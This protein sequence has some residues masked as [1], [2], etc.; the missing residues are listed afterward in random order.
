[1]GVSEVNLGFACLSYKFAMISK[2]GQK[3]SD[4]GGAACY[5]KKKDILESKLL[6]K[7]S[8]LAVILYLA[9]QSN[10]TVVFP[11]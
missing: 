11:F 1:M 9:N 6:E 4:A 10:F 3:F 8:G 5:I 7:F 2:Y